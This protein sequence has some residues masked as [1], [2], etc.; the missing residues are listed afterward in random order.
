VSEFDAMPIKKLPDLPRM[1]LTS[2]EIVRVHDRIRFKLDSQEALGEFCWFA[3]EYPRCYRF[4]FEG[5]EFRLRSIHSLMSSM[6]TD[7]AA[8][9]REAGEANLACAI[10]DQRA[11]Q[12]YWDFESFLSEVSIC[13]DLLA[14]V[15][16]PAFPTQSPPSFNRLCGWSTR[17]QM[18]D[19]F[20]REKPLWVQRLKDYRDCFT[21]YTPVDTI[22]SVGIRK[23]SDGWEIRAKLPVNPNVRD[24]LGFRYNRRTEV[25]RYSLAVYRHLI[26]FDRRLAEI[27]RRMYESGVYP[28]RTRDLFFVGTRAK[29]LK[30]AADDSASLRRRSG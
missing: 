12:I 18:V 5:A 24:I 19:A 30:G 14:R 26:A 8:M 13:L 25:L 27:V 9:V 17:H 21:H 11:R 6:S 29:G 22:Q 3:R 20:R 16:S 10:G 7:L 15:V 2:P 23:Y 4:H 28:V 1:P